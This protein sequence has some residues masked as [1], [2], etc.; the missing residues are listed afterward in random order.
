MDMNILDETFSS[1][2]VWLHIENVNVI[3]MNICTLRKNKNEEKAYPH[4]EF[5]LFLQKILERKKKEYV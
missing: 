4:S 5:N 2:Y 1:I 3:I